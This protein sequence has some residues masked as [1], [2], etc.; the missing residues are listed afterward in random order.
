MYQVLY[1]D[2]TETQ[3]VNL[4]GPADCG[5]LFRPVLSADQFKR[6]ARAN[7]CPPD[8]GVQVNGVV[9]PAWIRGRVRL[10]KAYVR[11]MASRRRVTHVRS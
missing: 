9:E 7:N 1:Q 3:K 8:G 6:W 5:R 11:E 2:E 10:R 4:I